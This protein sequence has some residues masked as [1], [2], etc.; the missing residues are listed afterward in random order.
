MHHCADVPE[1]MG[2]R[3]PR[4]VEFSNL[5]DLDSEALVQNP[6]RVGPIEFLSSRGIIRHAFNQLRTA[7]DER[8]PSRANERRCG[9]IRTEVPSSL[10]HDPSS[11]TAS[12]EAL[13]AFLRLFSGP[14]FVWPASLVPYN[15]R[16]LSEFGTKARSMLF[17]DAYHLMPRYMQGLCTPS[18]EQCAWKRIC[19]D[20]GKLGIE[21]T[22]A[23]RR[24]RYTP[25]GALS[26]RNG[27]SRGR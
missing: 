1:L 5:R 21:S 14:L 9:I 12:H 6:D 3:R 18:A 22:A 15:C 24:E 7:E 26:C 16:N 10:F 25:Y 17:L 8:P 23:I 20:I 13:C 27:G 11:L 2:G 19:K 4:R